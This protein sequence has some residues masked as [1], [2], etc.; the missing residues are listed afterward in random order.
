M[1]ARRPCKNKISRWIRDIRDI[2][3]CRSILQQEL[4]RDL[5]EYESLRSVVVVAANAIHWRG[6]YNK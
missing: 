6:K 4:D 3:D 1:R 2:N 5:D